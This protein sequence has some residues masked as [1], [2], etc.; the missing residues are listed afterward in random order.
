[1]A[2]TGQ[3]PPSERAP[4]CCAAPLRA[5]AEAE[6]ASQLSVWEVMVACE[7]GDRLMLVSDQPVRCSRL[8]DRHSHSLAASGRSF[9]YLQTHEMHLLRYMLL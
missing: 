8:R 2:V 5:A 9:L 7:V 4:R 3:L 1:V 6:P